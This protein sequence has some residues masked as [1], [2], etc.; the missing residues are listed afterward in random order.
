VAFGRIGARILLASVFLASLLGSAALPAAASGSTATQAQKIVRIAESEVGHRWAF[1]A[2]GPKRFDCSGLVT[3]VFRQAGLLARVGGKRR[4]VR[5][6]HA[7][8]KRHGRANMKAP[9]VGDL[10]V[11]GRNRH[12]GIYVGNGKA[13]SALYN[14]Y[15]VT[16]HTLSFIT[17][18]RITAYLHVKLTR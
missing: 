6:F 12:I 7:W 15:G 2:T 18:M 16:E 10:I 8:F 9:R 1:K 3:Y 4:T 14:P 11:W 17:N 5:G 13:V